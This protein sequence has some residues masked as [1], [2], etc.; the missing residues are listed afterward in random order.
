VQS[1]SSK[2]LHLW[3]QSAENEQNDHTQVRPLVG[4]THSALQQKQILAVIRRGIRPTGQLGHKVI[5]QMQQSWA[6]SHAANVLLSI[7][8]RR[9]CDTLSAVSAIKLG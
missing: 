5:H 9:R 3:F 6:K 8:T 1:T 4:V 7:P 2:Y